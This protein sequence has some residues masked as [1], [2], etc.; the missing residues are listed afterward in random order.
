[1]TD[2]RTLALSFEV[3]GLPPVKNGSL[4]LFTAGHR[5]AVRVRA[6]LQAAL[7][8]A[9]ETGWTP[10]DGPVELEVVLRCPPD[11]HQPGATAV[12]GGIADVLQNK[13]HAPHVGGLAHLGVLVDVALYVDDRQIRR[14]GY[15]EEPA[16]EMSYLVR[17]AA[18]DPAV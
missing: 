1:M 15:R 18:L 11:Q 5:Q 12:L 7:G 8:A 16:A 17:V 14:I 9:Q 13:R 6:L 3:A 4:S 2:T 10:L